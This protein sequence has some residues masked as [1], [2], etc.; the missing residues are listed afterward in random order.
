MKARLAK[1]TD[2]RPD[3]LSFI[4]RH[5]GDDDDIKGELATLEATQLTATLIVLGGGHMT[6]TLLAGTL[7]YLLRSDDK[8]RRLEKEIRETSTVS[9]RSPLP[10]FR[11]SRICWL[12]CE[13]HCASTVQSR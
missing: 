2:A 12:S 5:A 11:N 1:G 6:P 8:L 4:M 9:I 7:F 10:M 3:F 13:R